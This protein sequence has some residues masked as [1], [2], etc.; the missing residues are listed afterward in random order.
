MEFVGCEG[1]Y[2]LSGHTMYRCE[3]GEDGHAS[4][5]PL[6]DVECKSKYRLSV[7]K[8]TLTNLDYVNKTIM[9]RPY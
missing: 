5:S 1:D 6:V 7:I 8:F 9:K 3:N 2:T 4:W